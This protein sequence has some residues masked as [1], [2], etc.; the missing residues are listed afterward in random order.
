VQ[1][2]VGQWVWLWLQQWNVVGVT[3]TSPSKLGA[4]FDG[5]HQVVQRIGEV[6]YKLKLP[7]R[8]KIHDVFRVSLPN[9]LHGKVLPEPANILNA[10]LNHGV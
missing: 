10:R 4:K 3:A 9:I 1:F 2:D 7:A 6:S 5:P 8:A